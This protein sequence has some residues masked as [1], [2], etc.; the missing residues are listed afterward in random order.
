[1]AGWVAPVDQ[2][3]PVRDDRP[4]DEEGSHVATAT[5]QRDAFIE[6]MG[7][8]ALGA[9]ELAAILIGLRLGFY[10]ALHDGG[11]AT[12]AELASRTGTA[13]RPVREWL[14]H[15]AVNELLELVTDTPDARARRYGLP[16]AYAEVLL[17][18]TSLA[19]NAPTPVQALAVLA[20][21]PLVLDS[22]RTGAGFPFGAVGDEMRVGEGD[23]NKPS[24]L[25]PLGKAWIP[26]VADLDARL[27]AAPPAR[28]ADIGCGLG[29]A[30][31]GIA[32]AYPS[33][34][35]D[36]LDS[37]APSVELARRHALESGVAD[38]VTFRVG[39]AADTGLAGG[40]QLITV[41]E[42]FHD[43]SHPVRVLNELRRLLADDGS[44][45]IVDM[46]AGERFQAPGDDRDRYLYGWSMLHCLHGGLVDGGAGTG[47]V[48]RPDV[49]RA[50]AM[51]ASM[52]DV[53]ILPIDHD[54]WRFYRLRPGPAVG[55]A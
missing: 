52:S 38:R 2:D 25:G 44:L 22:F 1:L 6:R 47:T 23:A 32:L 37:D 14:E 21:M 29:W 19:Y 40:Y 18:P 35:V 39:D 30:S 26:S 46:K 10:Q 42:A 48:M 7:K 15:G 11:P 51:E 33:V 8:D 17:D 4:V 45:L 28:I 13:E 24:Y 53:E 49:L 3:A 20:S 41:L 16:P 31:I 50:Y 27:R 54:S 55:R 5:E 9:F 12:S 36:G 43:M 34:L